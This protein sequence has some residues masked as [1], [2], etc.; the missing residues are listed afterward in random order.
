MVGG[1]VHR[2]VVKILEEVAFE[3]CFEED[4]PPFR[5]IGEVLNEDLCVFIVYD[6]FGFKSEVVDV[7]LGC[8]L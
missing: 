1:I 7:L 4:P 6:V 3:V 2:V 8:L 5:S